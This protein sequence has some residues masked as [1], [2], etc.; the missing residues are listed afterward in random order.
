MKYHTERLLPQ[1]W[2][3]TI[4]LAIV[5]SGIGRATTF[6]DIAPGYVPDDIKALE[7]ICRT[8]KAAVAD[9]V[10]Q[11]GEIVVY[12][13]PLRSATLNKIWMWRKS[14]ESPIRP[15]QVFRLMWSIPRPAHSTI[16]GGESMTRIDPANGDVYMIRSRTCKHVLH[17]MKIATDGSNVFR[18]SSNLPAGAGRLDEFDV[19]DATPL[20][21]NVWFLLG[22]ALCCLDKF[23]GG[24]IQY[25]LGRWLS[26]AQLKILDLDTLVIF[27]QEGI[28]TFDVATKLLTRIADAE[29]T[30]TYPAIRPHPYRS[31]SFVVTSPYELA[32][33]E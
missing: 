32:V 33:Y 27:A 15:K 12:G 18:F 25:P 30:A 24:P 17:L 11:N 13:D 4:P 8:V 16:R 20:D 5:R 14:A 21:G 26:D 19:W 3:Y 2:A 23:S 6:S 28:F 7:A 22:R 29:M 10:W 31:R 1:T 9:G